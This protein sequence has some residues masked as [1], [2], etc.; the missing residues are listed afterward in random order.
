[1][2]TGVVLRAVELAV[3]ARCALPT[4]LAMLM[5]LND[6]SSAAG[7]HQPACLRQC[8]SSLPTAAATHIKPLAPG[9]PVPQTQANTQIVSSYQTRPSWPG[10][11]RGTATA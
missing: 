5:L 6:E 11:H 9:K 3:Q 8:C 2:G 7:P 1:M 4:G 10:R